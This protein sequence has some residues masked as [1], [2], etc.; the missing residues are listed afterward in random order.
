MI[1]AVFTPYPDERSS[2]VVPLASSI[3][4]LFVADAI[5]IP[6]EYRFRGE[7]SKHTT[8]AKALEYVWK[9]DYRKE[10]RKKVFN[11]NEYITAG[12]GTSVIYTGYDEYE[13]LQKDFTV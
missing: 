8:N 6:T 2:S 11:E 13:K 5:K 7:T 4:E 3:I 9:Y 12:F 1:D 10:N